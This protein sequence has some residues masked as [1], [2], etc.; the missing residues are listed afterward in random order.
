M[1]MKQAGKNVYKTMQGKIVDMDLLRQ[2]NELT[3]AIGNARVNARGDELGPGGKIVRSREQV[4]KE[5]YESQE[6][7]PDENPVARPNPQATQSNKDDSWVEDEEGN[8]VQKKSTRA[9]SKS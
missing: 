7:L 3:P 4:L 1:P 6:A 8:F 2:K 9:K 5:Y